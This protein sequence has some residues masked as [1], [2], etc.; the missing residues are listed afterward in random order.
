MGAL[1]HD[2]RGKSVLVT[3][4][5]RG[6]GLATALAFARRGAFVTITH[7]WDSAELEPIKAAFM[8]AGGRPPQIVQADVSK[9]Q[10]VRMVLE[11]VEASYERLDVLI[12]N[13]A[14]PGVVD[15]I[16]AYDRN[17]LIN[18]IDYSVWPLVTHTLAAREIFGKAPR[19]IIALSS[20]GVDAWHVNYDFGAASKAMLEALCRYLHYRLRDAGST[21]NVV[22]S[23]FV[24]TE[25][26][27]AAFGEAFVPF[28]KGWEPDAFSAPDEIAEAIFGLCS[29]LMDG[30]GGQVK[31]GRAHV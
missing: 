23:R 31:I 29:G 20:A 25:S 19:Y 12:S 18:S 27:D 26:L 2:Y 3:G 8:A 13:V 6:I 16:D 5:T 24:A 4:G 22:R 7:R 11:A 28:V 21:V 14:V 9:T 17:A 10:D 15:S 30:V 1:W